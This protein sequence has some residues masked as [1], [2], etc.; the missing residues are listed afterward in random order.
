[1]TLNI[2][3]SILFFFII[4][5][6]FI[7]LINRTKDKIQK[8]KNWIKYFTYFLIVNSILCCLLFLPN[9]FKFIAIVI[10][11]VSFWELFR[12]F[13]NSGKQNQKF[14]ISALLIFSFLLVF[15]VQFST[16][17]DYYPVFT[18][19]I[20]FSFDA[21]SQLTGQ[22]IGKRKIFP[23]IS[24]NKTAE[25]IAGGLFFSIISTFL[26]IDLLHTSIY[27]T[28]LTTIFICA[29]ALTGDLLA[30]YYKRK[31]VVKDFSNLIPGHG[32]FLDR[33]DSFIFSGALMSFVLIFFR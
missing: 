31:F 27:V 9:Y 7:I 24:P 17:T 4:G 18:F 8:R 30:S 33:F 12:V 10:L 19:Y 25:G 13:S 1:M 14:F 28:L 26:I 5:A 23:K 22:L 11:G 16:R 20:V 29:L 32:G 6:V 2:I 15:F 3:C 21:Y